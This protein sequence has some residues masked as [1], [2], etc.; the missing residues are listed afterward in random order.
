[1]CRLAKTENK[2]PHQANQRG[3]PYWSDARAGSS[4]S[5]SAKPTVVPKPTSSFPDRKWFLKLKIPP[6]KMVGPLNWTKMDIA[7]A[8]T[9]KAVSWPPD[10]KELNRVDQPLVTWP[11]NTVWSNGSNLVRVKMAPPSMATALA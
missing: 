10:D 7:L 4:K 8:R 11:G 2:S 1:M 3:G 5:R 9:L 6:R